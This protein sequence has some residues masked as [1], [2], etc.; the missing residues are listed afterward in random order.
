M[1]RLRLVSAYLAVVL[2]LTV[3]LYALPER[4]LWCFV[5]LGAAGVT[6]VVVGVLRHRPRLQ[7]PWWLLAAAM[8]MATLGITWWRW[9]LSLGRTPVPPS[10]TDALLLMGFVPLALAGL[11][12]LIRA[13][14]AS[15]DREGWLD[16]LILTAGTCLLAW[17][18]LI[19][20]FIRLL[21]LTATH[22]GLAVGYL[23][24]GVLILATIMRLAGVTP[25][26]PAAALLVTG[27]LGQLAAGAVFSLAEL[28]AAIPAL[29]VGSLLQIGFYAAWGTAALHPAM[30]V[31]TEPRPT[32]PVG[33]SQVRLLALVAAGLLA[34]A[35]LAVQVITGDVWGS[36]IAAALTTAVVLL[37]LVRVTGALAVSRRVVA[38]ERA[39][40][41][42][43]AA[44]VEATTVAEVAAAVTAAVAQLLPPRTPHR[45]AV[46]EELGRKGRAVPPDVP[47]A[48]VLAP[49]TVDPEI[50]GRLG[51]PEAVLC[52]PLVVIDETGAP[53]RVGALYIG[54]PRRSL[55]KLQTATGVLAN[56]AALALERIRLT[57][58][59][60]QR[61][62]EEYFRTWCRTPPT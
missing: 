49:Q 25:G 47:S 51:A 35:A 7:L 11:A 17:T 28:G 60:K 55:M 50:V 56:Q 15:R 39:L 43:G 6:A 38:R 23:A 58:E 62:S 8:L 46:Q 13:V 30:R 57:S 1:P 36:L 18:F 19:Q 20:P 45:V 22:R 34:P 26:N 33:L 16:T 9:Q 41:R 27:G 37:V 61:A 42:A 59:V 54:A 12:G 24:A 40:R 53:V 4:Q 44:L 14:L 3:L 10:V 5:A 21:G 29:Q 52:H 2:G 32:K 31:L 48:G